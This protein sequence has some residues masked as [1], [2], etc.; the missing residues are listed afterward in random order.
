MQAIKGGDATVKVKTIVL[1][2][3][4]FTAILFGDFCGTVD[5]AQAGTLQT[6]VT[7]AKAPVAASGGGATCSTCTSSTDA[8]FAKSYDSYADTQA[9]TYKFAWQFTTAGSKC[10]TG[11]ILWAYD[12]AAVGVGGTCEIWTDS[13]GS[14]G[15]IVGAGFTG[16]VADYGWHAEGAVSHEHLFASAQS[17]PAGTYW[18]ECTPEGSA[19]IGIGRATTL[20]GTIKYY[21][22]SWSASGWKVMIGVLGC[23]P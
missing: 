1:T 7:T 15:S 23:D 2:L 13:S 18:A 8:E 20:T 5:P 6:I 10:I 12:P 4:L 22:T 17:L 3:C 21:D 11:V 19:S 9:S 14:P 16:T